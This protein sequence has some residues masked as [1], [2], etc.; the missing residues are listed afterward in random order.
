MQCDHHFLVELFSFLSISFSSTFNSFLSSFLQKLLQNILNKPP[1][2]AQKLTK[3]FNSYQA[4]CY[5]ELVTKTVHFNR[6][7]NERILDMTR[8]GRCKVKSFAHSYTLLTTTVTNTTKSRPF[9][10]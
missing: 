10:S 2:Q 9:S 8:I 5:G 4:R 1:V 7:G 3:L 6:S